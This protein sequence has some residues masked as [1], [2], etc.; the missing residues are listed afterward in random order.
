MADVN[1]YIGIL[2]STATGAEARP[3]IVSVAT[4]LHENFV[5]DDLASE[6]AAFKADANLAVADTR[7]IIEEL[8]TELIDAGSEDAEEA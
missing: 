5:I 3:I 2:M 7:S 6:V 1:N 8:E 4:G